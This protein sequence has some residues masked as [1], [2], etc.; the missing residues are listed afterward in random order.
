MRKLLHTSWIFLLLALALPL[1]ALYY[2]TCTDAGLRTLATHLS[3][4]LGP[5]TLEIRGVS[6]NL[7]GGAHIEHIVV[8][9]RRVRVEADDAAVRIAVLPLAWQSL[10]VRT[11][12]FGTVRIERAPA[13][14]RTEYLEA[15]FPAGADDDPGR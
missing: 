3:R 1:G 13:P 8:D 7:A 2:L 5:V 4:R 6:G 15:A 12:T 10:R 14:E 9:H 11:A